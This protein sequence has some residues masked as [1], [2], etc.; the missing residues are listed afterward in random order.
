[1][2][3]MLLGAAAF[4]VS[5][6]GTTNSPTT[7]PSPI[8]TTSP[9]PTGSWLGAKQSPTTASSLTPS[10][11]SAAA[12]ASLAPTPQPV[13]GCTR[14]VDLDASGTTDVTADLQSFLD[15][16]SNHS[17][18]CFAAGGQYRVDGMIALDGRT[19]ITLDGQGA[20]I[21]G[22]VRTNSPKLRLQLG[23]DIVVRNLT[24]EGFNP[25]AGTSSAHLLGWEHGHGI[26]IYGT[27][28]V[29]LAPNVTLRNLSGD[30]IYITGGALSG[31]GFQWADGVTVSG[32]RVERNGRMGVALTDGARDIAVSRCV[33]DEIALY[34]F[35]IEPNGHSFSGVPAGAEDVRF[36]DNTI[37][38]YGIDPDLTP[39]VFAGTGDGPQ[40]NIE[41]SRN[42]VTGGA[43]RIGVWNVAGSGRSDFRI[44]DNRSSVRVAGHTMEFS[45][46]NDLVVSGNAQ[47]LSSGSLVSTTSST[48]AVIANNITR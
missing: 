22:T 10:P 18:V 42:V 1:M 23:A 40:R 21:F 15:A 41:F 28:R 39:W 20:R 19:G 43:L 31:G 14:L 16:S 25:D 5:G 44:V 6:I 48:N 13:A 11:S 24:I 2:A 4:S 3:G 26:G 37:G 45:G 27:Q 8:V 35:D 34:A 32:C 17:T 46:V 29:T 33:L 9:S 30:G 36:S 7:S 38:T 12:W 47:P